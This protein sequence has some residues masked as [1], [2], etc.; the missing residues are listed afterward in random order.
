MALTEIEFELPA[1]QYASMGYPG[2]KQGEV[3]TIILDAGVLLPDPAADGWFT[4]QQP[5]LPARFKQ[6]GAATYAFS[7]QIQEADIIKEAGEESATL[8]VL[9]GGV[10]LR[11]TCAPQADGRL[12]FGTWE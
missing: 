2:L 3:L 4:V 6:V 8:L 12:P 5:P 7:G 1:Q 11:V 10:P 9:C